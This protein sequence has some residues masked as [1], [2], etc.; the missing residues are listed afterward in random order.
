ME[1]D[2][3]NLVKANVKLIQIVSYE[4]V[5]MHKSLVGISKKLN[6][7]ISICKAGEKKVDILNTHNAERYITDELMLMLKSPY[8]DK[9]ITIQRQYDSGPFW[10]KIG[11]LR[12][13]KNSH[14]CTQLPLLIS[15]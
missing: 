6:K 7:V 1:K 5:G 15:K 12:L 10:R 14:S 4:S 9:N 11:Y 8:I 13:R 2:L 3:L